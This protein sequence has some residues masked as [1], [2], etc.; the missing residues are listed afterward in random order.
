MIF[1]RLQAFHTLVLLSGVFQDLQ[2]FTRVL[3][4]ITQVGSCLCYHAANGIWRKDERKKT[5][6]KDLAS[7]RGFSLSSIKSLKTASVT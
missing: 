1:V 2:V 4:R 7:N 6:A 3:W 5:L